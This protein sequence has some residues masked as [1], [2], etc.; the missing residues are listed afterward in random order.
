MIYELIKL[1][2]NKA[3]LL[4]RL[5]VKIIFLNEKLFVF[6]TINLNYSFFDFY[7]GLSHFDRM[8]ALSSHFTAEL[9]CI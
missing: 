6:I 7:L 5:E 1:I 9:N 4:V 8:P 3:K 2:Y